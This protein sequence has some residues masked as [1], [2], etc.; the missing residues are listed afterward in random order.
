MEPLSQQAS[1]QIS[2]GNPYKL[3]FFF[4]PSLAV[5]QQGG[6]AGPRVLPPDGAPS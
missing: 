2:G 4:T 1:E 5:A 6:P 3:D